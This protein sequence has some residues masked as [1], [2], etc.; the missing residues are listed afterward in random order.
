MSDALHRTCSSLSLVAACRSTAGFKVGYMVLPPASGPALQAAV[1]KQPYAVK[2]PFRCG[3]AGA[4]GCH[5][6]VIQNR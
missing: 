2:V 3:R 1:A 4:G 6:R 5:Y